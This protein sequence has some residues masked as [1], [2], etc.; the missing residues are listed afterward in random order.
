MSEM[1]TTLPSN[2]KVRDSERIDDEGKG[3]AAKPDDKKVKLECVARKAGDK[4]YDERP[5]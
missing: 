1:Q 5:K 3:G 4:T 2:C